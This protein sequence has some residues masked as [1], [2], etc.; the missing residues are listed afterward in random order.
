V[1]ESQSHSRT[2]KAKDE[3]AP[4]PTAQSAPAGNLDEVAPLYGV[5][6]PSSLP[7]AQLVEN[8]GPLLGEPVWVVGAA[9]AD[10][11]PESEMTVDEAK[12]LVQQWLD[13]PVEVDPAQQEEA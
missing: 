5:T 2:S 1:A 11:D 4:T 13:R 6:P 7:V 10:K 12:T 8:S 9:L 3:A